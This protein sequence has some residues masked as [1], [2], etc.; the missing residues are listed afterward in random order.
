MHHASCGD[1]QDSGGVP[2]VLSGTPVLP[3]ELGDAG[4]SPAW[5]WQ[6]GDTLGWQSRRS[7]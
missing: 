1:Q 7:L 2:G 4:S 3:R 5:G 6:C